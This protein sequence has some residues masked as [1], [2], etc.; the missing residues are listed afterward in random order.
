MG[1][2]IGLLVAVVVDV[3]AAFGCGVDGAF[4]CGGPLAVDADLCTFSTRGCC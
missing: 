1:G 3:V 2:F 4:A